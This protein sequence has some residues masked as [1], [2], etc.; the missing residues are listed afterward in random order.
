MPSR[1]L[2]LSSLTLRFCQSVG[3]SNFDKF[4]EE[5]TVRLISSCARLCEAFGKLNWGVIATS[6]SK[7]YRSP[8]MTTLL[9]SLLDSHLCNFPLSAR[10]G[11]SDKDGDDLDDDDDNDEDP[12]VNSSHS[13]VVNTGNDTL[14]QFRWVEVDLCPLEISY[15]SFH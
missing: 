5:G 7:C 10:N 4:G 14:V 9:P 3:T 15:I 8:N 12:I 13:N 1:L 2:P 11:E 6:T